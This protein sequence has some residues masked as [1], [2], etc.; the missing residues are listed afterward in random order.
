MGRGPF[1]LSPCPFGAI[2]LGVMKRAVI[3]GAGNIGRGFIGQLFT[4]SGYESTF[5]DIDR[6]LLDRLN[7]ERAYTIQ[8]VDNQ[9][10]RSLRMGPVRALHADD[11]PAVLQAIA[12]AEMAATA[13][14]ARA[15]PFVAPNLAAGIHERH[16]RGITSPLNCII[17]ENLK[18]AAAI[19]RDMVAEHL[20]PDDRAYAEEHIGFVDTVIGRMVPPLTP[21]MREQDPTTIRVEPYKELP[22]DRGGF[23]G[24]VPAIVA[25]EA[26]DH[27][28]AY[29][30]RK[31]YVHNCGHAVLAYLGYLRGYTYGYEALA[32]PDIAAVLDRAWAESIAGQV[33]RY[34]VE[35]GW[36]QAHAADLKAR[37]ANRALGDTVLRLGRD[38]VR[39]LG[40]TDRLVAPARLAEQAGV[41]PRALAQTIAAALSFDPADDPI[42][43]DLQRQLA[44][45]GLGTVLSEVCGIAPGEPLADLIRQ[46]F[47][48]PFFHHS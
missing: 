19:V 12:E 34:G 22:V 42:A 28:A 8:L 6:V 11:C 15:L 48:S 17:C 35:A 33:A 43:V 39:K 31:L 40:P 4:E 18:G 20:D 24:P 3:F 29:T 27:F 46:E 32:D 9:G 30:A 25:L 1:G 37:F 21:E 5:I 44:E 45:R 38:P 16:V 13:V 47:R 26:C 23:V 36:L 7:A 10:T 41:A 2:I 14:G